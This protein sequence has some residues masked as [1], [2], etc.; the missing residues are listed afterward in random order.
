MERQA[1]CHHREISVREID[2]SRDRSLAN[3]GRRM[4]TVSCRSG[5]SNAGFTLVEMLAATALM[6]IAL[7]ILAVITSQWLP[8]WNV[9]LARTQAN[10]RL[11]MAVDRLSRDIA[12]AEFITPS[13]RSLVPL[14]EGAPGSVTFVR[15]SFGPNAGAGLDLV[16]YAMA[17]GPQE[18]SLIR[19]TA[20]FQ[21]GENVRIDALKFSNPV[22]LLRAPYE[23]SFSY[24]GDDRI[25]LNSWVRQAWLPR[26]VRFTIRNVKSKVVLSGSAA[27]VLHAEAPV[28]CLD[29]KSWDDCSKV[30]KARLQ[31]EMQRATL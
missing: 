31:S 1:G 30:I 25:W 11:S 5:S 19:T 20:N 29:A 10:E 2:S 6:G 26:A 7:A 24:A 12:S 28:D 9:G 8:N 17:G 23:L 16:R 27:T 13:G 15:T 18:A 3:Q 14:F 21:S 4:N 22:V